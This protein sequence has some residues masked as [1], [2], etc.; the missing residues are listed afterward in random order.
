MGRIQFFG[1]LDPSF[2]SGWQKYNPYFICKNITLSLPKKL[3]SSSEKAQK[4]R[5]HENTRHIERSEYSSV[6]SVTQYS[7]LQR[8]SSTLDVGGLPSMMRSLV[9]W[10]G[11]STQMVVV[12][13]SRVRTATD[14]SAMYSSER[15]SQR[16]I[17]VTVWT[18]SRWSSWKY[19]IVPVILKYEES[20]LPIR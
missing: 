3:V 18:H 4:P 2:H 16:R 11:L 19:L 12:L 17:L 8:W 13:R 1:I 14:I 20:M 10:S 5:T 15:S 6:G 9:V 7:S